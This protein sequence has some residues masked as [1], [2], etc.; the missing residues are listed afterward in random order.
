MR[1]L[2]E[3]EDAVSQIIG[4]ILL[5]GLTVIMV[6]IIAASVLAFKFPESAPHAKIVVVE[7]KG[8]MGTLYKNTIFLKH[9]G[10]DAL[11]ENDTKIIITGKGCAYTGTGSSCILGDMRA[12]Y[13]DLSGEN[14]IDTC[15][16]EIVE[17]TSWDAGDTITLYGSDGRDL[18]FYGWHNNADSKWKLDD[19]TVVLVTIID[20]KTN[21][22]IAVSH[23]TVKDA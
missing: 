2:G 15:D 5:L 1:K 4:V 7:A 8:D 22:V 9:K 21:E 19:S 12:T 13:E 3:C 17:G 16:N 6:S 18:D 14:C 23:A 10:G 11:H 20:T